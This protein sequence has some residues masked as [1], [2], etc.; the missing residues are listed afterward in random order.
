MGS[1]RKKEEREGCGRLWRMNRR[2]GNR[3]VDSEG[4]KTTVPLCTVKR[5][6]WGGKGRGLRR[7]SRKGNWKKLCVRGGALGDKGERLTLLRVKKATLGFRRGQ[8]RK[9]RTAWGFWKTSERESEKNKGPQGENM[10][11]GRG[12]FPWARLAKNKIWKRTEEL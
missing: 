8:I 1:T 10:E 5:E 11:K 12:S 9:E 7:K 3:I 6:W 4:A 2:E